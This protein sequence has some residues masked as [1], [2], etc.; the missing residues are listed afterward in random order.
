[1]IKRGETIKTKPIKRFISIL[2][3]LSIAVS[4]WMLPAPSAKAASSVVESA[5]SW[6]IAIANDNSH[7]YSQSSRW[8]PDYDCSSFVISAFRYAGVNTGTSTYTGNMR[9]QFTQHGFQW[10][11]WSQIGSMS[12]LRRGD[13]LLNEV[14]HTEIYLGN[15]QNVGAHS[16]R[17]YPQTGDQTGTEVS[18]SGYYYHPWNGV[19]RYNDTEVCRCS[20]DYAGEYYVSTNSLPLTMR[21]GHGTGYSTVTTI[22]KGSRVYVSKAD[23]SWAH[24]EWDN[25]RGYCAM[26]YLTRVEQQTR[27]FNLHVWISDTE[28]GEVPENF[29]VGKRYYLCYELI[30]EATGKKATDTSGM[31]YRVTET[32]RNSNGTVYEYTYDNSNCNWISIVCGEEDT[33]T[34]TV[35]ISGNI[36]LSCSVAFEAWADFAATFKV[37]AWEGDESKTISQINAGEKVYCSYWIRDKYTKKNLNDV[38]TRCTLGEGYTVTID[39]Y[40]PDGKRVKTSSFKNKDNIWIDF[41]PEK[42]G[43]YKY[44][45]T[46]SGVLHGSKERTFTVVEKKAEETY[47]VTYTDGVAGETVFADQKT[48][49]LKKDAY[50]PE[51]KG[52]PVRE[53]YIFKGWSPEVSIKVIGDATYKALWEKEERP[54][55]PADPDTPEEIYTVVYIDGVYDEEIFED[56]IISN[57][58][59][60]SDMPRFKGTPV[61]NGYTFKGWSPRIT[62]TVTGNVVYTALWEKEN[63]GEP[64]ANPD[65]PEETYTVAYTDGVSGEEIF[66]DQINNNLKKGTDTPGFKGTPVRAGYTFKGWSPEVAKKVTGNII[67]KARWEKTDTHIPAKPDDPNHPDGSDK[68][69]PGETDDPGGTDTPPGGTDDPGGTD[70]PPGETDDP[71]ISG[72]QPGGAAEKNPVKKSGLV[73]KR[74]SKNVTVKWFL[75]MK[76]KGTQVR[77]KDVK[78][79]VV[80]WKV[81]KK[82]RTK[83][84]KASKKSFKFKK[85]RKQKG[86]VQVTFKLKNGKSV[87]LKKV[88]F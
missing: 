22:P 21:S 1:M 32:I 6:A 28:M 23:G 36:N 85:S 38:T 9:S 75:P 47:T 86:W 77:K 46:V 29:T 31:N 34:G 80:K 58:K 4:A 51:F 65:T 60:G 57:L 11:P 52:T 72:Q 70:T 27:S 45:G 14:Q 82:T 83:T 78:R 63:T 18:V 59:K 84:L 10:I 5:I 62:G 40:D 42:T 67:Y 61:R 39:I 2:L 56:Q 50:T 54:N 76:N 15:G 49:N 30:D 37:W 17:G 8:G 55:P 16:N 25:H 64:P 43:E 44:V 20:S 41:I 71:D 81:G 26:S 73:V 88:K 7:G 79:I 33:Y 69:P 74:G 19:L 68:T 53:G 48:G 24:V 12:N 3:S 87:K 13:I 66:A 35:T